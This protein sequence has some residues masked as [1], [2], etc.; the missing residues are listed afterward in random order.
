MKP[1]GTCV[2]ADEEKLT[3]GV[4]KILINLIKEK[5]LSS[6]TCNELRFLN[7][8]TTSMLKIV[9]NLYIWRETVV[10]TGNRVDLVLGR[11]V[12]I[13]FWKLVYDALILMNVPKDALITE[14][15][16]VAL[17]KHLTANPNTVFTICKYIWRKFGLCVMYPN[18]KHELITDGNFLFNFGS[19]LPNKTILSVLF[20]ILYWGNDNEE[21]V[22]RRILKNILITFLIVNG[23]IFIDRNIFTMNYG[24]VGILEL[25]CEDIIGLHGLHFQGCPYK[26]SCVENEKE[27]VY[28]NFINLFNNNILK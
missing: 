20:C 10:N 18:I 27:S 11:K 12:P 16:S 19:V 22:L 23:Y 28:Y 15:G 2:L 5:P 17:C 3:P 7:L 24:C 8:V 25:I 26:N 21:L 6:F 9:V 13:Q 14:T 1:L 4:K